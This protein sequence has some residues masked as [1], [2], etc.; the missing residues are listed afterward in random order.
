[1]LA[2]PFLLLSSYVLHSPDQK[3]EIR[4]RA[5]SGIQYDVLAAGKM[6]LQDSVASIDIDHTTLGRNVTV[7]TTKERSVD[8]TIEPQVRQKFAK[9]RDHFNELRIDT[10]QGLT[11]VFRAYNEGAAYRLETSLPAAQVKVYGEEAAFNFADNYTVFYPQEETLFSHNERQYLPR[12]LAEIPRTA[13]ATLPAVVDVDGT[14]V[15]I[16]ESDVEDY[17][18]LWLR[19]TSGAGIAATFPPYP[20]KETL[21][22][23]RDYKVTQAA[24]YIAVTRGTRTFPWRLMGVAYQDGD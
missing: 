6:L 12:K 8:Q 4:I 2:L 14:K 13:I 21:E 10:G 1:M 3:I 15:A 18:G 16:A 17:P 20:L 7:K 24:D 19:G 5:G 11:I 9:I 23:D 22:R